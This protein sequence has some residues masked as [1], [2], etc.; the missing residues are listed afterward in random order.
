MN[1]WNSVKTVSTVPFW[2]FLFTWILSLAKVFLSPWGVTRKVEVYLW[3]RTAPLKNHRNI[4]P[5]VVLQSRHTHTRYTGVLSTASTAV[6]RDSQVQLPRPCG[7]RWA[8][9]TA[10]CWRELALHGWQSCFSSW[11]GSLSWLPVGPESVPVCAKGWQ[12]AAGGEG[13][14]ASQHGLYKEVGSWT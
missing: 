13:G 4:G 9:E 7:L 1:L 3:G 2:S 11:F 12:E 14:K 10:T 6:E 8:E 5:A